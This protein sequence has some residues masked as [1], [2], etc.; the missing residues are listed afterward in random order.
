MPGSLGG[1]VTSEVPLGCRLFRH[2][3]ANLSELRLAVFKLYIINWLRLIKR[4][5]FAE[6]ALGGGDNQNEIL[7]SS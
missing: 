6:P 3:P 1:R 2:Q 5:T 7:I 4:L